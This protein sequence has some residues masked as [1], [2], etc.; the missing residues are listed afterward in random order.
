MYTKYSTAGWKGNL[1]GQTP[2]TKAGG[3]YGNEP[4]LGEAKLPDYENGAAITYREFDVNNKIAGMNRDSER[5]V[6]GSNGKVYYTDN[7]YKTFI[8]VR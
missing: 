6:V 5:F 7:H 4:F 8:E 1:P 2:G 3:S